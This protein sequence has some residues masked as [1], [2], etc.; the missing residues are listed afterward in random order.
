MACRVKSLL[1]ASL[2]VL[3]SLLLASTAD[4][5]WAALTALDA[6]PQKRPAS[7]AEAGALA[8]EHLGK[9][10]RAVRDFL[11][12]YGG[13]PHAFEARLRLARTLQLKADIQDQRVTSPEVDTLLSQAEKMAKPEQEAD[14]RFAR[15]SYT[16]RQWRTPDAQQRQHLYDMAK[17]FQSKFPQDR[18][19]PALLAEVATRFDLDPKRKRALLIDARL[20]ARDEELQARITDDFKRLDQVG[21]P[22]SLRFESPGGPAFDV[23]DYRGKVVVLIFFAAWSQP[24]VEAIAAVEKALPSLPKQEVQLFGVS[25]DTKPEPLEAL[26]KERK[27]TWPVICDG[28]GWESPL[29]RG[30]GVNTLP[31]VWLLDRQG[32]LRSLDGADRLIGQVRELVSR[33]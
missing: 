17:S 1:L 9:Q 10:E 11:R 5:D 18:R 29:V 30:L 6:G 32:V 23:A 21:L 20:L 28:K 25:L 16:M 26:A 14:V 3:P 12:D 8:I 7:P 33:R 31:T 2:L 15:L 27:I 13:N 22:V 4:E 19:L 24:S